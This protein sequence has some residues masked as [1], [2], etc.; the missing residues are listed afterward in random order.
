[1]RARLMAAAAA[2]AWLLATTAM[3]ATTGVTGQGAPINNYQ[4]SIVLTQSLQTVG[5]FPTRDCS[6]CGAVST[7]GTIHTFAGAYGPYGQP[8]ANGQ[9]NSISQNTALFSI[10]G[11]TYGGNG[12]S[13]FANPDLTGRAAIGVGQGPGL[14]NQVLGEQSGQAQNIMTLSQLPAH[15]HGLGGGNFTGVTGGATPMDNMQPTLALTYGIA[16]SG[17]FPSGATDPFI[18][19]VSLFTGNFAPNGYMMADGSLLSIQQNQALFAVIGTT[20]GGDGLQTFALPDL[21]GRVAVG[22][23]DGVTL[24]ETFGGETTLLTNGN[25]PAHDHSLPSSG[26]TLDDGGGLPFDNAQPSLGLNYLIALNGFFPTRDGSGGW[27]SP[28]ATLGEIVAFAGN[29]APQGFAFADGQLLPI[30]QNQALFAIIGCTYGGNCINTFALPDLRG[31]TIIGAGNGFNVGD[32]LGERNTTLSIAQLAPHDHSLP[33]IGP[34]PGPGVPE[35]ATWALMIGG[36]GLAGAALRRR[37]A[38]AG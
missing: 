20:Y 30:N 36:F 10:M 6:L 17:I 27:P 7:L 32:L 13:T 38:A 3:A 25:L 19:Q 21:R 24:G 34:G 28:D 33:D 23:G 5:I 2:G 14:T 22:V 11:T 9:L 12:I 31:R 15:D 35:P 1:M 29:F 16:V 8:L 18:G 26:F 4:P 37:R